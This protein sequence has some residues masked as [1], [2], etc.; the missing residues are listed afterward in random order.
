MS[1][2]SEHDIELRQHA[3]EAVKHAFPVLL[4]DFTDQWFDK[5]VDVVI[6]TYLYDDYL[7]RHVNDPR[8]IPGTSVDRAHQII[9][10]KG[11]TWR[12]TDTWGSTGLKTRPG[13]PCAKS[14]SHLFVGRCCADCGLVY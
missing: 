7:Q 6:D 4:T 12:S 13:T 14:G 1:A 5:L 3:V 11:P 8:R 2:M 9:P 10:W